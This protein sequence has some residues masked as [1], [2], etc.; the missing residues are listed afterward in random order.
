MPD[1]QESNAAKSLGFC[2]L[3]ESE[4]LVWLMLR[5]WGHPFAED[6]DY[7]SGLLE[8]AA[9]VLNLAAARPDDQAFVEG[10]PAADMN[11]VAAIW[12]AE[13]RAI[14]DDRTASREDTD[15]RLK[16][17]QT[18]RHTLPSCFCAQEDLS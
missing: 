15:A 3:F 6:E 4:L 7:R 12:Y 13:F 1:K 16:W 17:L 9:E 18:V 8:T 2:A 5:N 11:L 14:E 10:V